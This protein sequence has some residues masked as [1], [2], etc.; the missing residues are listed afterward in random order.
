MHH[1]TLNQSDQCLAG[2]FEIEVGCVKD[3]GVFAL[4]KGRIF[5]MEL[6]FIAHLNL[7]D[8]LFK[9]E[10]FAFCLKFLHTA[11]CAGFGGCSVIDLKIGIGEN[12]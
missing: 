7:F 12:D 10:G 4:N 5:A 2:L 1:S 9:I 3:D 6:S 8:D 11:H